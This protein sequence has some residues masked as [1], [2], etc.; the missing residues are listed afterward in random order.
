M[1]VLGGVKKREADSYQVQFD[2][3]ALPAAKC[4]LCE[5]LSHSVGITSTLL[6]VKE[7]GLASSRVPSRFVL[8]LMDRCASLT[9]KITIYVYVQVFEW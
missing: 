8:H 9:R 1:H 2:T 4:Q 5:Y 3:R 6:E 7:V